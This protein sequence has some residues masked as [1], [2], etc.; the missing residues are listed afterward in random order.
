VTL[1]AELIMLRVSVPAPLTPP[2]FHRGPS[3]SSKAARDQ[4]ATRRHMRVTIPSDYIAVGL[5]MSVGSEP[6]SGAPAAGRSP[7][8][9]IRYVAGAP[10]RGMRA[11]LIL[12]RVW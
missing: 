9:M 11:H 5:D 4:S 12:V 10:G 6:V 8:V 1:R 2:D 7:R 3:G